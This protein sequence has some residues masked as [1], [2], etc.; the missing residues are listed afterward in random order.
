MEELDTSERDYLDCSRD[1]VNN[2]N[3]G[4]L[5]D[6]QNFSARGVRPTDNCNN[7]YYNTAI[8]AFT[9]ERLI[10]SPDGIVGGTGTGAFIPGYQSS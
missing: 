5:I 3:G 9:G 6:R 7:L 4:G 2:P 1:Y 10:P 8:D